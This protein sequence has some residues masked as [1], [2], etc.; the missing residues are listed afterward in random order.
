MVTSASD[1][2][3]VGVP[4]NVDDF[5]VSKTADPVVQVGQFELGNHKSEDPVSRTTSND[6]GGVPIVRLPA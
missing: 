6:W 5:E 4:L 3:D 2:L 1:E